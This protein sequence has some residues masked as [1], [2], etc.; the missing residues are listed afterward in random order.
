MNN[1]RIYI[2]VGLV[3]LLLL[4][5]ALLFKGA[6]KKYN[7][8]RP[9]KWIVLNP[10]GTSI[11]TG[12]LKDV[13][14]GEELVIIRDSLGNN[15]ALEQ[16]STNNYVFVGQGMHMNSSDVNHLLDFVANGNMPSFPARSFLTT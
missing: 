9:I 15:L 14:G 10:T 2:I 16:D 3:V 4:I 12:L 13:A 7:G 1:R 6:R 8:K 5:L 11:I